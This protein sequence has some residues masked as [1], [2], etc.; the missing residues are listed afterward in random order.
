[1][2][3]ATSTIKCI[4]LVFNFVFALLSLGICFLGFIINS[5]A[6]SLQDASGGQIVVLSTL[7]ILT[8]AMVFFVAFFGCCGVMRESHCMIVSYTSIL[9]LLFLIEA[10]LGVAAL[11]NKSSLESIS[12]Q[13]LN[14][15]LTGFYDSKDKREFLD[16][17]QTDLRCCGVE[18]PEDWKGSIPLSCCNLA[19]SN[20]S[21][22]GSEEI[23]TQGC[24]PILVDQAKTLANF[25]GVVAIGV[26]FMKIIGM[27][28]SL[29]LVNSI[30]NDKRRGYA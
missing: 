7:L 24:S 16:R 21:Y 6:A 30:R 8:G 23:Y 10:C 25:L 9:L 19:D 17:V 27:I 22:C 1:M 20:R 18:G 2:S 12:E 13:T 11:L 4:L 29:C 28:F 15:M 5:K 26:A 14:D 3:L